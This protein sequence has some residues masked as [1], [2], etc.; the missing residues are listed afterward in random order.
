MLQSAVRSRQ[1]VPTLKV[2]AQ[3]SDDI[4]PRDRNLPL[5]LGREFGELHGDRHCDAISRAR[6]TTQ[7]GSRFDSSRTRCARRRDCRDGGA[8][9]TRAPRS[10]IGEL[11]SIARDLGAARERAR[12]RGGRA[13][14][15]AGQAT[16]QRRSHQRDLAHGEPGHAPSRVARRR[17]PRARRTRRGEA[18]VAARRPP[19]ERLSLLELGELSSAI[20]GGVRAPCAPCAASCRLRPRPGCAPRTATPPR[21]SRPRR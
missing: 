2:Q 3:R 12:C 21:A 16:P 13:L 6:S 1:F 5:L 17:G 18:R 8:T 20:S 10:V 19:H 4:D 11:E 7:V 14:V 15:G 9:R